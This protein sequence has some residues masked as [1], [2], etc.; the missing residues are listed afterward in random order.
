V[1]VWESF[2][3]VFLPLFLSL[4]L[5]SGKKGRAERKGEEGS[6]GD[7]EGDRVDGLEGEKQ[8]VSIFLYLERK[9][10]EGKTYPGT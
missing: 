2:R 9:G 10:R 3:S 1:W 8:A 4:W 5:A 7:D 6:R